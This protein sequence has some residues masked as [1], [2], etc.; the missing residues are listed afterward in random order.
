MRPIG[1]WSMSITLS[2]CSSPS[3]AS[4][5]PGSSRA[6]FSLRATARYSVSIRNVD[7][8]PPDTP[9]TAVNRPSGMSMVMFLRLFSRAPFTVSRRPLVGLR[10]CL[11]EGICLKPVRYC[12]VRLSGLAITWS[13]V[14]SATT[15][16]PWMPAPGPISTTWSAVRIA[17]SSC[18]TTS[19][20][21]A[22]VAQR[23]QRVEQPGIVALMQSD[24]GLVQH[25]EHAGQA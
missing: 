15:A 13:G 5:S 2:S 19:T 12:P 3:M 9:V 1:L 11:G 24:R 8:P 10:R 23:L 21:V 17:S 20:R 14:P 22:H 25:I 4:C 18:S 6:L 7:L 16:P